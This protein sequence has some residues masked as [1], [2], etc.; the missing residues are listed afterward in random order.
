MAAASLTP[1]TG[2][3]GESIPDPFTLEEIAEF[4]KETGL[5]EFQQVSIRSLIVRLDRWAKQDKLPMRRPRGGR[6]PRVV[7]YTAML[8][9]HARRH[10]APGR[11]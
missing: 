10:P 9:A 2:T 6:G 7:S 11:G 5:P 1:D 8:E 4:F 3:A